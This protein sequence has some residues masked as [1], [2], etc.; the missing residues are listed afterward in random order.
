MGIAPFTIDI[1]APSDDYIV[2]NFPAIDRGFRDT[3]SSWVGVDHDLTSG[4]HKFGVGLATARDAITNWVTGSMWVHLDAL[5]DAGLPSLQVR[6]TTWKDMSKILLQIHSEWVAGQFAD[7]NTITV[8]GGSLNSDWSATNFFKVDVS[9]NF[10]LENPTNLPTGTTAAA[11]TWVYELTQDG[12]GG[13]VIVLG[14]R[15]RTA[16]GQALVLT[17]TAG[18]IDILYCTLLSSGDIHVEIARDSK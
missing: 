14:T 4:H 12:T 18:A 3:V 8:S 6:D 1:T 11:G 10:T 7:W 17:T 9:A 2:A 5:E 13:R 16:L 15:Y